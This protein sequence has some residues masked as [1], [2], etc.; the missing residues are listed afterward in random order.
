MLY[1]SNQLINP[2]KMDYDQY[3]RVKELKKRYSG[4]FDE[5][6]SLDNF[7]QKLNRHILDLISKLIEK[8]SLFEHNSIEQDMSLTEVMECGWFI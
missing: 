8:E 5:Y 3:I 6:N 7:R 4:L 1:F 2:D